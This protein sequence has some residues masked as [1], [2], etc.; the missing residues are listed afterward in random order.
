MLRRWPVLTAFLFAAV[1]YGDT[2]ESPPFRIHYPPELDPLAR[3][4][5]SILHEGEAEYT[6]YL[7]LGD[8]PVDVHLF[9]S[10]AA[11]QE[12]AGEW[13]TRRVQGFARS[14]Q[15]LIAL[16]SPA[17]LDAAADYPGIVR[18]EL[19]HVLID[20]NIP[21]A[22]IPRWF[23]EGLAMMLSREN[24]IQNAWS[25]ARLA[26]EGGLRPLDELDASFAEPG[27]EWQ[28][29]AAYEQSLSLTRY[30]RERMG[31]EAFWLLVRD[32]HETPLHEALE[33]RGLPV[34]AIESAWRREVRREAAFAAIVSG[35]AAFQIA[36]VLCVI[37]IWRRVKRKRR[38]MMEWEEEEDSAGEFVDEEQQ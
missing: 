28:F 23:N 12:F 14:G 22:H 10:H 9:S 21:A 34:D 29:G 27:D 6:R 20:R 8:A 25:T 30:L 33:R 37:A 19:L 24:R 32:L 11:F 36:A 13:P 16:K 15:R 2:M 7:P 38:L 4:T 3:Q 5:A 31:N 17:L 26:L 1:A 35:F 18:H